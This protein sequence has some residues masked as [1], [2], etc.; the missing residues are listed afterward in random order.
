M[1]ARFKAGVQYGDW[2]GTASADDIGNGDVHDFLKSNGLIK[3]DEY[4]VGLEL[5][6]GENHPG[7]PAQPIIKAYIVDKPDFDTV[8]DKLKSV[9][10]PIEVREVRLE[11]SLDESVGFFKRFNVVLTR[12]GLELIGREYTVI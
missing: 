9:D 11:V 12:K 10:G 8:A 4:L 3:V 7:R 2:E 5:Y 1:M 6:I